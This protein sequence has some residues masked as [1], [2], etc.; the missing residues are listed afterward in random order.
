M[1]KVTYREAP[2]QW[3]MAGLKAGCLNRIHRLFRQQP[4]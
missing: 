2:G 1:G 4:E 3:T